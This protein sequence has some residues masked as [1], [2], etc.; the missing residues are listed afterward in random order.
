MDR[1]KKIQKKPVKIAAPV[2]PTP[3]PEKPARK[4][5]I[6]GAL[7]SKAIKAIRTA[8]AAVVTDNKDLFAISRNPFVY[9]TVLVNELP[10]QVKERPAP[11]ALPHSIHGSAF[12]TRCFFITTN[13]FKKTNKAVLQS[14]GG[15][16]KAVSYD[17]FR[18]K[19]HQYKDRLTTLKE[20]D[21]FFCD[22]RIQSILR[23]HCGAHFFRQKKYPM[24]LDFQ[25]HIEEGTEAISEE[26]LK[27][28]LDNAVQ[29]TTYFTQGNGPEYSVKVGR[30]DGLTDDQLL[31]N[32]KAGLKGLLKVLIDRGCRL[33]NL[34]RVSVKGEQTESF[35][36]YSHLTPAEKTAMR[37]ALASD[38]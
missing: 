15:N 30:L 11:V 12:N 19:Y 7:L 28:I 1:S 38:S 17:Q 29:E 24:G 25:T 4:L 27:E 23:K 34:R 2:A 32:A 3:A 18:K 36:L 14:L 31:K 21:L 9:L 26:K 6:D 35:P 22:S 10:D 13:Q 33:A 16:W 20:F 37:K 5:D 8:H